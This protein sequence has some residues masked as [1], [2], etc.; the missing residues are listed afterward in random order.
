MKTLFEL[1]FENLEIL[2]NLTRKGPIITFYNGPFNI[3]KLC[4][5]NYAGT[6]LKI[7]VRITNAD[8]NP[9]PLHTIP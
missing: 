6:T 2:K 1:K 3:I 5:I 8:H 4:L 9:A 7:P